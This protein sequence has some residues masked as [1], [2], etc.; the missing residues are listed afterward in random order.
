MAF[1]SLDFYSEVLQQESH[2]RVLIPER[3]DGLGYRPLT[4]EEGKH[5]VLVLLH[6]LGDGASA[7]TRYT[8]V[9]RYARRYGLAV[10]MPEVGRSFYSD[11]KHGEAYW[12]YVSRELLQKCYEFFPQISQ[13]RED[14]YAA[15][16][17]MG[18]YGALKLALQAPG[19]FCFAGALSAAP[20]IVARAE[21]QF[22]DDP[23]F[24]SNLG[25][26]EELRGSVSDLFDAAEKL[27][28]S[29][30]KLPQIMMW[31]GTEDF[32][33]QDNAR[34]YEH[35]QKLGYPV[36]FRESTGDHQWKYWD[37]EI[38]T[39]LDRICAD[40]GVSYVIW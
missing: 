9:E 17:S 7:W 10:V 3:R 4:N 22:R 16:L 19:D 32:L 11:L 34:F 12:T 35:L 26:P 30:K 39:V 28:E 2:L 27:A 23:L 14:H 25:S 1:A 29:G 37:Q 33:Y 36:E 20:D 18:G 5:P 31:C 6:G 40:R 24:R 15:G 13:K 38:Q 8:A 21:T